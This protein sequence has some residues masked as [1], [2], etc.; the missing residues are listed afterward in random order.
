[1]NDLSKFQRVVIALLIIN[2]CLTL[3]VAANSSAP[4]NKTTTVYSVGPQGIPGKQGIQG[5]HG[6]D[7][8]TIQGPKGDTVYN[9]IPVIIQGQKADPCT[10]RKEESGA[11]IVCPDGS[12]VRI[13]KAK[14]G[15]N[16]A[17][18]TNGQQLEL[19][20]NGMTGDIEQK[21]TEDFG[22]QILYRKC[23]LKDTCND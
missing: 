5:L 22:W 13:E 9:P 14:D 23:E 11:L 3:S 10:I 4:V 6:K 18:G 21:Y 7:G 17:D 1:M 12:Y 16:G 19:R 20:K 15:I 2:F 8:L